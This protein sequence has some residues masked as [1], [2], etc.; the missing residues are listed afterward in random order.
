[1]VALEP[2]YIPIIDPAGV[3][4]KSATPVYSCHSIGD[5]PLPSGFSEK[6]IAAII[7]QSG[8]VLGSAKGLQIDKSRRTNKRNLFKNNRLRLNKKNGGPNDAFTEQGMVWDKFN[9][10]HQLRSYETI[11]QIGERSDFSIE[12][13][14]FKN[15]L[16]QA[17]WYQ[18]QIDKGLVGTQ[19]ELGR[20]IGVSR[21]RIANVLRLVGLEEEIKEFLL[22][23]GE[24]D[25][26]IKLVR[27]HKLIPLLDLGR[28]EQLERF[29]EMMGGEDG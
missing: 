13:K 26:R 12:K 2:V 27:E 14:V 29:G 17:L 18:E 24:E 1:L 22:S 15:P 4:Q 5:T 25:E 9:I 16:K 11:F 6:P 8:E 3:E 21:S 7:E 23:I 19:K 20:K 10:Y 28:E